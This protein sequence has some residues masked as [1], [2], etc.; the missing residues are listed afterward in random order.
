MRCRSFIAISLGLALLWGLV[1][2]AVAPLPPGFVS[3]FLWQNA[4][5]QFGGF[6]AIEIDASGQLFIAITDKTYVVSAQISRDVRGRIIRINAG[7]LRQLLGRDR[8][9]FGDYQRDTEGLAIA[10]D[11]TAYV[12]FEQNPRIVRFDTLPGPGVLLPRHPDFKTMRKNGALEALAI[13]ADG[14]L[15]TL[16]EIPTGPV[17]KTPVYRFQNGAW[18]QPF[19]LQ[20]PDLFRPVAADFGP[21]G[22]FYLLERQ[23]H[24][25]LGFSNRVRR[26]EL[27]PDGLTKPETLIQSRPGQHDNLEGLSVWRDASGLLRLTMVSDNNFL[28]LQRTEIVEYRVPD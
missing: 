24:G 10:P 6:S 20:T 23:F 13:D 4:D 5:L 28:F 26:F 27:G 8:K 2:S 15:Y 7:P 22:R 25:L 16:P 21:D 17:G 18:D 1:G 14:T 19:T 9:P 3:A 12:S 11:G